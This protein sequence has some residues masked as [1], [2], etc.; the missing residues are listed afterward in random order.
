[1]LARLSLLSLLLTT[2]LPAT[3]GQT[4]NVTCLPYYD[5]TSNSQKQTPCQV[6]SSLLSLCNGG[7]PFDVVPLSAGQHYQGPTTVSGSNPCMCNTVTYS[8][9]AACG[10]C[11]G[12]S[13]LRWS[14]WSTNCP[15]VS[16]RQFSQPLP[17]GL[18][19]PAWAYLDVKEKDAFDQFLAKGNANSTESTSALAPT[20]T[21]QTGP[22]TSTALSDTT[23]SDSEA[24][25]SA[26]AESSEGEGA[27]TP[28]PDL[29]KANRVG[30]AVVGSILGV[31]LIFGV[32]TIALKRRR[33]AR[34]PHPSED[35]PQAVTKPGSGGAQPA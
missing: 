29:K 31:A 11:Q 21:S 3:Y 17:S 16:L 34:Y 14:E 33:R 26:T 10:L 25:A 6:A 13:V 27:E 12:R 15:I 35:Q 24:S 7:K 20:T 32:G 2:G 1:M 4:S 28:K 23:T 22:A 19:V 9:M 18:R 30:G 8:L 5:W